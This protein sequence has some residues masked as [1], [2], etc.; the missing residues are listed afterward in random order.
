MI[1]WPS[2][3]C[4]INLILYCAGSFVASG[5]LESYVTHGFFTPVSSPGELTGKRKDKVEYIVDFIRD[6]LSTYAR[7]ALPFVSDAHR[8]VQEAVKNSSLPDASFI[9]DGLRGLTALDELYESITLNHIARRASVTQ[10]VALLTLY[11]KGFSKPTLRFTGGS[12][13]DV[14]GKLDDNAVDI[15]KAAALVDKLKLAV[16]REEMPGHLPVC[17]GVLT[18]SLGLSLERSQ[19][20]HLFLCARGVL[21]AAVRINLIGPYASQQ[22]LLHAVRPIV[23]AEATSCAA[24]RTGLRFPV[25]TNGEDVFDEEIMTNNGPAMTWPLGE[26]LAGRHDLQHS[27]VFNS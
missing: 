3:I 13:N 17:W 7:T 21:S 20:L 25:S 9:D 6:S 2:C 12:I 11:S 18:A 27:R 22:L 19:F 4:V 26:I 23:K 1:Y 8:V 5:G 15:E 16:R 10:G 14:Q 24:L